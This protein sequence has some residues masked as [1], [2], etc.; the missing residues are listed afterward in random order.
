MDTEKA[1]GFKAKTWLVTGRKLYHNTTYEKLPTRFQLLSQDRVPELV[2]SILSVDVGQEIPEVS[3]LLQ[4]DSQFRLVLERLGQKFQ[5]INLK[6]SLD[7]NC[8]RSKPEGPIDTEKVYSFL[9][10]ILLNLKSE[11]SSLV[12]GGTSPIKDLQKVL[13]KLL[14]K[15]ISPSTKMT[16]GEIMSGVKVKSLQEHWIQKYRGAAK[17]NI[18][19]KIRCWIVRHFFWKIL[20]SFFHCT[21]STHKKHQMFFYRK[22]GW[23]AM[24]DTALHSLT[25]SGRL[26]PLTSS[27]RKKFQAKSDAP[28]TV[29]I[30]FIPKR[31]LTEVR[32]IT[33]SEKAK[34]L[35]PSLVTL[36]RNYS[37]MFAAKA[38]LGGK[39]LGQR[40][41]SLVQAVDSKKDI[42]WI[43]A[44]ITDAFGSILLKKLTEI[45][46]DC[47]DRSLP[48]RDVSLRES[49]EK[50]IR[51]LMLRTVSLKWGGKE[52]MFYV[53]KGVLQGDPLSS[54][55]CDIYYGHMVTTILSQFLTPPHGTEEIFLRGVDDFLFISTDKS[56]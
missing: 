37:Q 20:D 45:L 24:C 3:T 46:K 42:F 19:A 21:E 1:H 10:A 8:P 18:C 12:G 16:V 14:C 55:L 43:T 47:R 56:R 29:R 34:D 5:K 35:D 53:E 28:P 9:N 41:E 30:R 13:T 15:S 50:L 54:D 4:N 52:K 33:R 22:S 26:R 11:V 31:N 44:D 23:Q 36:V 2:Q 17:V 39:I 48:V 7:K 40:W 25:S 38:D 27:Y 49:T 32:T 6:A 51:R